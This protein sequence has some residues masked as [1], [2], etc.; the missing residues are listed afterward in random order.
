[1]IDRVFGQY[2]IV[3]KLGE[4]GMGVVYRARDQ[5]LQRDVALKFL[6]GTLDVH[7]RQLLLRE[8]RAASALS[9]PNVCTVHEVGEAGGE[10]YIVMELVEGNPLSASIGSSGLPYQTVIRYGVQIAAALSH[11]HARNIVHRDLKSTNVVINPEGLVKVLDFGVARRVAVEAQDDGTRTMDTLEA[12]AT[13]GGTLAYMSPEVLRGETG[14]FRSDIWALGVLLHEAL[15]GEMPF[16][17]RT[18]FEV[19][20]AILNEAPAPLPARV[21]SGLAAIIQRCL[22]KEP[23]LRYQRAG[24]AQAALEAVQSAS[25]LPEPAGEPRGTRTLRASRHQASHGEEWRRHIARRHH[26]GRLSPA[27]RCAAHALGYS[28]AVLSRTGHV[29]ARLGWP[30]GAP[31]HLGFDIQHAV[32]RVPTL[33]RRLR[34]D[35]DRTQR[36]AHP[37]SSRFGRDAQEYLADLPRS[38]DTAGCHLLRRRT[39]GAVRVPR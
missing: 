32:G 23:A 26:E 2:R 35:L 4:G 37:V 31:P 36:G 7:A 17:G 6:G 15:S 25:V 39:G 21:P 9:H 3:S 28:G 24:E 19:S 34:K 12:P 18:A 10:F 13:T 1:M 30:G 8:A 14:D 5:I 29:C 22:T 38:C 27:L 33:Q 16:R 11:A 20:S